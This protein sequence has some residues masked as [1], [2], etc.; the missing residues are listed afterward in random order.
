[1]IIPVIIIF[2]SLA[3]VFTGLVIVGRWA[4]GDEKPIEPMSDHPRCDCGRPG[5]W[6]GDRYGDRHY[7]CEKCWKETHKDN[8]IAADQHSNS[9]DQ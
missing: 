5:I 6:F 4:V 1:M 2:L 8:P 7:M 9:E 3:L